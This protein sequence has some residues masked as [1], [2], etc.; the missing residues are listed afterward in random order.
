MRKNVDINILWT[1]FICRWNCHSCVIYSIF[2]ISKR[3]ANSHNCINFNRFIN[4]FETFMVSLDFR[5]A[6]KGMRITRAL[7]RREINEIIA[8]VPKRFLNRGAQSEPSISNWI[9][10]GGTGSKLLILNG[11]ACYWL[12]IC[13]PK[14]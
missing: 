5:L 4:Q 11:K 9:F 1:H 2:C 12:A 7:S 13:T 8:S 6:Q 14:E 3:T 10:F